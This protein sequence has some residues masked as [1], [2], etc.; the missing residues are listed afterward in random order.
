MPINSGPLADLPTAASEG[1]AAVWRRS[2]MKAFKALA[3]LQ[4]IV[5][6][7]HTLFYIPVCLLRF[8]LSMLAEATRVSR[9]IK[10]AHGWRLRSIV[11][12]PVSITVIHSPSSIPAGGHCVQKDSKMSRALRHQQKQSWRL[13][14]VHAGSGNVTSVTPGTSGEGSFHLEVF[15]LFGSIH[16]ELPPHRYVHVVFSPGVTDTSVYRI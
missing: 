1:A 13:S 4:R 2:S 6:K 5:K 9:C 3:N 14:R 12:Y 7:T 10:H 8:C 15:T 11:D 16:R